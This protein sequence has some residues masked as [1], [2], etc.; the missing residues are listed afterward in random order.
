[1]STEETAQA[2]RLMARNGAPVVISVPRAG[3]PTV[4]SGPSWER[5]VALMAARGE[6]PRRKAD[7][8]RSI[9]RAAGLN[10]PCFGG[11]VRVSLVYDFG[12]AVA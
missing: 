5:L 8:P 1:M 11:G 6:R 7:I 9:A 12:G 2:L 3:T 4:T 10:H